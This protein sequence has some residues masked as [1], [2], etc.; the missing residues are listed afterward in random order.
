[1]TL[2]PYETADRGE[3]W[4]RERPLPPGLRERLGSVLGLDRPPKS[5]SDLLASLPAVRPQHTGVDKARLCCEEISR[6]E[7]RIEG[8]D[9]VTYTH[10]VLDALILPMLVDKRAEIISRGPLGGEVH[11]TVGPGQVASEPP[12][13]VVSLGTALRDGDDP[14]EVLCPYINAFATYADYARWAKQTP[15][16]ATVALSLPEAVVLAAQLA[17]PS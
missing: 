12:G 3:G 5:V 10:C 13:A 9:T 17:S 8:E 11:I 15:E 1:M 14:Y 4:P 16:A 2:R 7:V 6:H